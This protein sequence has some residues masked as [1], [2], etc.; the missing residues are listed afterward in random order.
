MCGCL[1]CAPY[2]GPGLQPRHVPC[3]GIESVT[4][5]VHRLALNP[6]SHTGQGFIVFL[7]PWSIFVLGESFHHKASFNFV[8]SDFNVNICNNMVYKKSYSPRF[9]S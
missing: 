9:E 4:P 8:D 3:L 7:Y 6:L 2:W 5:L 1:S